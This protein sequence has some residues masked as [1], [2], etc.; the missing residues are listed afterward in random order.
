MGI[1]LESFSLNELCLNIDVLGKCKESIQSLNSAVVLRLE[2]LKD[3]EEILVI[4][5]DV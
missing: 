4:C 2:M 5:E 1:N 3:C